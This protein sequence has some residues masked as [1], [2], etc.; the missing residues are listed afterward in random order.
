[1]L[2][3]GRAINATTTLT[4][5]AALGRVGHGAMSDDD[6]DD[7]SGEQ[8]LSLPSAHPVA[9]LVATP[10]TSRCISRA[11]ACVRTPVVL[12]S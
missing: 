5:A 1:M 4:C 10:C 6:D 8:A 7:G 2:A 11:R 3:T 9:S 12:R